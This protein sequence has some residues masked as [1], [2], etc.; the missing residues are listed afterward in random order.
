MPIIQSSLVVLL[1][2]LEDRHM[3]SRN[4]VLDVA[5]VVIGAAVIDQENVVRPLCPV[6]LSPFAY[7]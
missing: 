3:P 1:G 7:G 5:E 2:I 6:V 4:N